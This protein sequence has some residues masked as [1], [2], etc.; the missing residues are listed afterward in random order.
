[1][2]D[3]DI[4]DKSVRPGWRRASRLFK[5]Q[6]QPAEFAQAAGGALAKVLRE[7]GGL[8]GASEWFALVQD[9]VAARL[10]GHSAFARVYG[11][12]HKYGH[13][14]HVKLAAKVARRLLVEIGGGVRMRGDL[15]EAF[16]SQFCR[17]VA[18]NGFFGPIRPKL[19]GRHF[20]TRAE[21]QH[22]ESECREALE[23][24]V[25]RLGKALAADP[26]AE[27]LRAPSLRRTPKPTTEELLH[28]PIT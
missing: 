16:C 10:D 17:E 15:R 25:E 21:A 19:I 6:A 23:R 9:R 24:Y 13:D 12:E 3:L 8:P 1:M 14:R 26:E 18:D 20:A 28:T 27:R 5:G 22:R 4:I 7:H 2:P 11:L